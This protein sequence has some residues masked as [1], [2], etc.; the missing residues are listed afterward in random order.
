MPS[1]Y[2]MHFPSQGS[3]GSI[4]GQMDTCANWAGIA[5]HMRRRL[6]RHDR[7]SWGPSWHCMPSGFRYD[8]PDIPG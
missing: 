4:P 6:Q 7:D 8:A 1:M 5:M 3:N 2:P